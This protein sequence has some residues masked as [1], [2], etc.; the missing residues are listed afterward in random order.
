MSTAR[1]VQL[2]RLNE[3]LISLEK[4]VEVLFKG[5]FFPEIKKKYSSS[6]HT[7]QVGVAI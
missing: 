2:L 4:T 5:C 7:K 6:S 1:D 3:R